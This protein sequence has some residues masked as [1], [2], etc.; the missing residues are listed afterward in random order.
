[1]MSNSIQTC[2]CANRIFVH[3]SIHDEFCAKLV[4]RMAKTLK[5]GPGFDENVTLGPL[6]TEKAIA[7]VLYALIII[8]I[9]IHDK[10]MQKI[11][12]LW[13]V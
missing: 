13:Y 12:I 11:F 5:T 4:S 1:M 10:S 7:K 8:I 2:I 6:I 3:D 9:Y